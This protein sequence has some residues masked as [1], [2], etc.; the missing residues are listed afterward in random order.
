[1]TT[2]RPRC[3]GA[4]SLDRCRPRSR[5]GRPRAPVCRPVPC[6]SCRALGR[7]F[8]SANDRT[9][10]APVPAGGGSRARNFQGARNRLRTV[11]RPGPLPRASSAD[12]G[13]AGKR[14]AL[15][16]RHRLAAGCLQPL[17]GFNLAARLAVGR[18]R[19]RICSGGLLCGGHRPTDLLRPLWLL[20]K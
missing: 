19:R 15:H 8:S 14:G 10:R 4:R 5:R 1:M 2:C 9:G 13:M 17:Q 7:A 16:R 11:D 18:A 6:G 3:R 12:G 20:S